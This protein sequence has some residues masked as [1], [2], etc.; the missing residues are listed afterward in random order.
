MHSTIDS[1]WNP[2]DQLIE[3]G[4][5]QLSTSLGGFDISEAYCVV[6]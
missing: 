3:S 1:M 4:F 2:G 5:E 6:G